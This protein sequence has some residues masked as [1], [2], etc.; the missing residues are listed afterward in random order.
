MC[1]CLLVLLPFGDEWTLLQ[2]RARTNDRH[3]LTVHPRTTYGQ[4]Y[5]EVKIKHD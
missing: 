3:L 1:C 5:P 4:T 2:C